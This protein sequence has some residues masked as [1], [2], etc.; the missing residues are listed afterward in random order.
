MSE[1]TCSH[2][3]LLWWIYFFKSPPVAKTKYFG[4]NTTC[5]LQFFK[6]V[7]HS[8]CREKLR[9]IIHSFKRTGFFRRISLSHPFFYVGWF[10]FM[11]GIW[12]CHRKN[13]S[14][15]FFEGPSR[16]RTQTERTGRLLNVLCTFNLR[17]MS[18]Q[19]TVFILT[20]ELAVIYCSGNS[21]G[22]QQ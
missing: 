9:P 22:S 14:H 1:S 15:P 4:Q 16:H 8:I 18:T 5:S 17:H 7:S 2:S 19:E 13:G 20:R 10:F 12:F 11:Q 6:V 21:F 3:I